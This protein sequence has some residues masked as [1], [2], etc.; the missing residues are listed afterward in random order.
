MLR[1]RGAPG[2]TGICAGQRKEV[3]ETLIKAEREKKIHVLFANA[4]WLQ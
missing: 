3:V 1:G 2:Q 4:E